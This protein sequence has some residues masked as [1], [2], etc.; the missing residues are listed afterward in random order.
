MRA[1]FKVF[2]D[3]V[4]ILLLFFFWFF[5]GHNVCEILAP[6]IGT[7]HAPPALEGEVI[8]TGRPWKSQEAKLLLVG[9]YGS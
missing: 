4:A 2:I 1:S 7:E 6:Q 9:H 8:A 5:F 3:F